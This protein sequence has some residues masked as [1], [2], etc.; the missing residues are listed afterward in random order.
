MA[1]SDLVQRLQAVFRRR[2]D[3]LDNYGSQPSSKCSACSEMTYH[4]TYDDMWG[5]CSTCLKIMVGLSIIYL[6]YVIIK[7]S[8]FL[9]KCFYG[10]SLLDN[11]P[12]KVM[13]MGLQHITGKEYMASKKAC[14]FVHAEWCG[15]CKEAMPKVTEMAAGMKGV[16]FFAVQE[17]QNSPELNITAFPMFILFREGKEVDRIVGAD[18]PKLKTSLAD[19]VAS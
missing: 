18:L 12:T 11:V 6:L 8:G 10:E 13:G 14:L 3:D 16:E 7:R 15:H 19:L 2:Y 9:K 1:N 17:P 5:E 4:D